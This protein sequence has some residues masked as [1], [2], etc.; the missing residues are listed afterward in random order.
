[1]KRRKAAR[2]ERLDLPP[3]LMDGGNGSDGQM[4]A[5]G[6]EGEGPLLCRVLDRHLP[7]RDGPSIRSRQAGQVNHLI[8]EHGGP[9]GHKAL[10]QNLI[11]HIGPR[12]CDTPHPGLVT[13]CYRA[14]SK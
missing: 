5:I 2:F 13:R 11:Q 1:M 14:W 4:P 8:R 7:E 3:L 10:V 12:A 9:G 6:Q